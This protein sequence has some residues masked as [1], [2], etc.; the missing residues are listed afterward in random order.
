MSNEEIART[1]SEFA[2]RTAANAALVCCK[3]EGSYKMENAVLKKYNPEFE[4]CASELAG[5]IEKIIRHFGGV[6]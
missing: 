5:Y 2:V 3:Y 6:K 4:T 1:I